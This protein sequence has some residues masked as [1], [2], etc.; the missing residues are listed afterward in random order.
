MNKE[1]GSIFWYNNLENLSFSILTK[2]KFY[3]ASPTDK[4]LV[5]L[6]TLD[7]GSVSALDQLG[8]WSG[9]T[10]R[11]FGTSSSHTSNTALNFVSRKIGINLKPEEWID[12]GE[13]FCDFL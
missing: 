1:A 5:N 9:G 8:F 13:I 3:H 4:V 10:Q 6:A 2:W 11:S 12:P 7:G